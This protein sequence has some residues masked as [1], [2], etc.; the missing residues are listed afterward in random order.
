MI[1]KAS[2]FKV[3]G[4]PDSF[5]AILLIFAFILLLSPYF[6]GGDFG[7]FKIPAISQSA[8]KWL[9]VMGPIAFILCA[10]SFLPVF[11]VITTTSTN[12]ANGS[13]ATASPTLTPTVTSTPILTPAAGSANAIG[14]QALGVKWF[15]AMIRDDT[16]AL[17]QMSDFPF[18]FDNE[19]LAG[20]DDMRQHFQKLSSNPHSDTSKLQLKSVKAKTI[21]EW[22]K[23]GFD[24]TRDRLLKS[25]TYKDD[26]FLVILMIGNGEHEEGTVLYIRRAG[27][28]IKLAGW[29]N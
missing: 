1:D 9:K 12:N 5:G 14:A 25:I 29:W 19:I 16:T 7:V 15:A 23:D 17:I 13:T 28:E 8:K 10:L 2:L 11:P 18:Y 6:S 27:D 3:S 26:D 20:P 24:A 4:L 22:Q 21:A